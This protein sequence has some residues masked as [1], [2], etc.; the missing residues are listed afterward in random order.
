MKTI[1][2]KYFKTNK[3][4]TFLKVEIYYDIGGM[5]YFT[6]G[7]KARGYYLSARPVEKERNFES[8]VAFTGYYSLL[9]GV[10]KQSKKGETEA[11]KIATKERIEELI[12]A[13][14]KGIESNSD[15]EL[16]EEVTTLE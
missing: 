3:D 16:A 13:V 7:H 10:A 11:L 5:N 15:L 1:A 14:L 9:L 2:T 6:S 8:F 12:N 4:K